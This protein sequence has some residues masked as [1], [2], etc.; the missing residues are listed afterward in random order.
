MADR[1]LV[2]ADLPREVSERDLVIVIA[3]AMQ[4]HDS[5]RLYTIAM[6]LFEPIASTV[7][8]DS[9]Q[10]ITIGRQAL[11]DLDDAFIEQFG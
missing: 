9:D 7:E 3:I 6:G 5:N 10:H 2:E 1:D 4:E 8:V 11:I